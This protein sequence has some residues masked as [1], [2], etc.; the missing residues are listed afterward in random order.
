[1]F[2]FKAQKNE[3]FK[4]KTSLKIKQQT[5]CFLLSKQISVAPKQCEPTQTVTCTYLSSTTEAKHWVREILTE[6]KANRISA[7]KLKQT[8]NLLYLRRGKSRLIKTTIID[9]LEAKK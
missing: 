8:S 9:Q 5:I 7:I 1:M 2:A 3:W 6:G 4:T